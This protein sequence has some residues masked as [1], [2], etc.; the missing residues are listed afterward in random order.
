VK[1][2]TWNVNSIRARMESVALLLDEYSPD[3]V[4]LQETKVVDNLFPLEAFSD[5]G[6]E[7]AHW[8]FSAWNGVAIASRVGLEGVVRGFR[9]GVDEEARALFARC[10]GLQCGSVY[11]PNGRSLDDPHYQYKLDWLTDLAT[12]ARSVSPCAAII[13]GD[14]N[15]APQ[16]IDVWDPAEL[17]GMTHVSD[18]ERQAL[19]EIL[20]AG[21]VDSFRV[22]HE[23]EAFTWWDYRQG[24]FRRNR[25]MRIDLLLASH[26]LAKRLTEVRVLRDLRT[27]ARPS[28]HAPL[29]CTLSD[30]GLTG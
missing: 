19:G 21:F 6:Y 14:F 5:R 22:L 25:G 24:A 17:V 8:G 28:D 26:P 13:G 18:A 16:D 9:D 11:I 7:V 15:I 3:I 10:G 20:R 27:V 30:E 12:W 4:L 23:E 1:V 2:V 29:L